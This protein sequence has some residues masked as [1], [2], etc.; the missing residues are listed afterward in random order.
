MA[1]QVSGYWQNVPLYSHSTE[2]PLPCPCPVVGP[3]GLKFPFKIFFYVCWLIGQEVLS[4]PRGYLLP[5]IEIYKI[6]KPL[7]KYFMFQRSAHM[8]THALLCG[9]SLW[10]MLRVLLSSLLPNLNSWVLGLY[11]LTSPGR[12]HSLRRS[13]SLLWFGVERVR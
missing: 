3:E 8:N 5:V 9:V 7:V 13:G 6:L 11:F 10:H 4:A 1:N 2:V 12:G